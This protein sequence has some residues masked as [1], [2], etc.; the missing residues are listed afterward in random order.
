MARIA[1]KKTVDNN[2]G[3]LKVIDGIDKSKVKDV[4]DFGRFTVVIL[5]DECI[6]HTHIGFEI[7]QKAWSMGLDG[8]A[9]TTSL[10]SWLCNLVDMKKEVKGKENDI[11][12]NTDVTYEDVLDSM[13]IITEANLCHPITAFIDMDAAVKFSNERIKFLGEMQ[14]KLEDAENTPIQDETEEDLKKNY[15]HGQ[16]AIMAEEVAKTLKG[17]EK[18]YDTNKGLV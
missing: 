4:A 17:E 7:R 14:K 18:M 13:I 5:M 16:K 6:F 15:E 8:K 1:K 2:A 3:L 12:P 11:Y 10:Y 9:V